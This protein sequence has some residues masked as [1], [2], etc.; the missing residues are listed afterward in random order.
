MSKTLDRETTARECARMGDVVRRYFE[1]SGLTYAE[2]SRRTGIPVSTVR[3]RIQGKPGNWSLVEV[4]L[5]SVLFGM[6]ASELFEPLA[7]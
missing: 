6:S 2:V 5:F 4:A 3:T 1:A 7:A